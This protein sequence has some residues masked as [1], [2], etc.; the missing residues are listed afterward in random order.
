MAE[1]LP[2]LPLEARQRGF[3]LLRE[4]M[5]SLEPRFDQALF[6]Y[7]DQ[8]LRDMARQQMKAVEFELLPNGRC[9][10]DGHQVRFSG[11]GLALAWLVL[12]TEQDATDEAI[13]ATW[14]FPNEKRPAAC[15]RQALSRAADAVERC[16]PVLASAI[17]AIGTQR[18]ILV[19]M[20]PVEGIRCTSPALARLC[21]PR[22][23]QGESRRRC[24]PIV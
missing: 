4:W 13:S 11:K 3:H 10:V 12:V 9:A 5:A 8:H 14:A 22:S 18:G 6:A 23:L 17:R 20:H 1:H 7:L 24:P 19:L 16:S 21:K 15:A 2:P